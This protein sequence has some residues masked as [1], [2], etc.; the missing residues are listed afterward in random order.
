[1][2]TPRAATRYKI[3]LKIE[4]AFRRNVDPTVLRAAARAALTDQAAPVP[5]DLT[6]LIAGD[7]ELRTLNRDFLGIDR[8]TDVLSFPSDEPD[9]ANGRLYLGDVAISFP[10][11]RMAAQRG[12]HPVKAELQLLVVHAVLHLL[13][14]DHARP[15]EKARMWAA[16]T[17]ILASLKAAISGPS[18]DGPAVS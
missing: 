10:Q 16:Q 14:H 8:P 6:I 9:P 7:G 12:G 18:D 17:A 13:G 4:P 1:M 2:S 3:N 11:A 5:C 15:A